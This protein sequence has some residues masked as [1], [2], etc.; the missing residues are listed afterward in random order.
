MGLLSFLATAIGG[1]VIFILWVIMCLAIGGFAY[2]YH[3]VGKELKKYPQWKE[4]LSIKSRIKVKM[5]IVATCAKEVTFE[6]EDG[7]KVELNISRMYW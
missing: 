2:E 1:I 4:G 5:T 3:S 7:T 6:L